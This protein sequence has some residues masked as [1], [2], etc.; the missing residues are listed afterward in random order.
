[1]TET[2]REARRRD[3]DRVVVTTL[4]W[5]LV[6]NLLVAGLKL[7]FGYLAGSVSMLADGLHSVLDSGSN[8]VGLAAIRIARKGPDA[9]HP[10]GHRKFESIAAL[11]I[12]G[13][14]FAT[15][16][17]VFREV[18]RRFAGEHHVEP[19]AVTFVVVVG[20]LVVNLA[21]TRYERKV[22]ERTRSSILIADSK[23]T[24][25][26]VYVSLSVLVSLVAAVLSAPIMDVVVGLLIVGFI[27]YTGYQ[28]VRDSLG[29]LADAQV[30]EPAQVAQIAMASQEVLHVHRIRSRGLPD[31]I[32]VDLHIHVH[33]EMTT[34]DAHEVA[35]GVSDRIRDEIEGVTDVV[36]HVEPHGHHDDVPENGNRE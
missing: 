25:S 11:A 18:L 28:I 7:L 3:R 8:V 19:T 12:A 26:D 34:E 5:I 31:D 4:S 33:P 14:L 29:V 10:Y 21:I 16:F 36:V 6:A 27:G 17:E 23:H 9:E 35:H 22:G 20:T 24:L 15:C 1:V 2:A 32:H 13:F 30:L